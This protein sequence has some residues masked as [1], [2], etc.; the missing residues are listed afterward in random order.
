M[1]A[2]LFGNEG[3]KSIA[4][5]S[6]EAG[7]GPVEHEGTVKRDFLFSFSGKT[8]REGHAVVAARDVVQET[9]A[10]GMDD[11]GMY[12]AGKR[13]IAAVQRDGVLKAGKKHV[14]ARGGLYGQK[15]MIASCVASPDAAGGIVAAAVGEEPLAVHVA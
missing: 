3:I 10:F 13:D 11:A 9:P 1:E 15:S 6:D 12:A 8:E 2:S 5:G 7:R 4:C 14:S